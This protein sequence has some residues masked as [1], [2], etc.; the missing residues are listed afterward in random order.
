MF[1]ASYIA[2]VSRTDPP[3]DFVA[4]ILSVEKLHDVYLNV[5]TVSEMQDDSTDSA[6]VRCRSNIRLL[7]D[8]PEHGGSLGSWV[9]EER[10]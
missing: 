6:A 4:N 5:N 9:D 8:Y 2:Y 1:F 10:S 3:F 7:R